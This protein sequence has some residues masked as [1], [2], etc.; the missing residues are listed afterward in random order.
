MDPIFTLPYSEY[1]AISVFSRIFPKGQYAIL[2]PTSR[3]QAGI[4]FV[5]MKIGTRRV[6]RIQVKS[7]RTYESE[8][9]PGSKNKNRGPKMTLWFGNFRKSYQQ[10]IADLYLFLGVYPAY[11]LKK[12]VSRAAWKTVLLAMKDSE[13]GR[14]L[15]SVK[16]SKGRDD[17]FF[18]VSFNPSERGSVDEVTLTRGAGT[19]KKASWSKYLLDRRRNRI[20]RMLR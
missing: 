8:E 20:L 18:Y 15:R 14:F 3:Q 11:S 13:T 10:G 19:R 2:V 5:V 9:K 7:S 4:D 1:A 17:R 6:L 12:P 16:T